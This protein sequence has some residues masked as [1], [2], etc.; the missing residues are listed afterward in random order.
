MSRLLIHER[1]W[2]Q[3]EDRF[4]AGVTTPWDIRVV[5]DAAL[6]QELPSADAMLTLSLRAESLPA[7]SKLRLL[8]YP[9]AGVTHDSGEQLPKGCALVNCFEHETPIAEYV[10]MSV[11]MHAIGVV[12]KA[13][14]LRQGE[15]VGSGRIGGRTH[16]EVQGKTLGLIGFGHIG[17]AVA[18]RAEAFGM[19]VMSMRS[20]QPERLA[21]IVSESDYL[22]V[23]CPLNAQSRGLIGAAELSKMKPSACLINVS[24]AEVVAEDALYDALRTHRIAGAVLDVWYQYPSGESQRGYGS[25][26]P[27]HELPNVLGTPHLSAWT[28]GMIERRIARMCENLDHLSR[29]EPLERVVLTGTW[30]MPA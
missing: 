6:H 30:E 4:R 5:D 9:G 24:R 26:L 28:D 22:V 2:S 27:F 14:R 13:G 16:A 21:A 17:Q 23:A 15:W 10:M 7:A 11:L 29:G 19:R 12:E 18:V 25:R 20:G 8:L 1:Q 3:Y